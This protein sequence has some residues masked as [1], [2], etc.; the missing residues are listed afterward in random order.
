MWNE[1]VEYTR[2]ESKSTEHDEATM[3]STTQHP[4]QRILLP[5]NQLFMPGRFKQV[6]RTWNVQ[7][8]QPSVKT[9]AH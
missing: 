6:Q 7:S 2:R 3:T 9:N 4:Q 1:G 8:L 5:L